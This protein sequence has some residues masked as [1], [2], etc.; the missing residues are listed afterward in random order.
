MCSYTSR[1]LSGPGCVRST[2][3]KPSSTRLKAIAAK[4]PRPI[5]G[6]SSGILGIIGCGRFRSRA[7]GDDYLGRNRLQAL[8]RFPQATPRGN[9]CSRIDRRMSSPLQRPSPTCTHAPSVRMSAYSDL[10]PPVWQGSARGPF[11]P[12]WLPRPCSQKTRASVLL[13]PTYRH[14]KFPT[15]RAFVESLASLRQTNS[16]Q[17]QILHSWVIKWRSAL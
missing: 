11:S 3:D 9:W 8:S 13:A 6:S 17:G 4:S 1:L 7:V 5:L 10:K 15:A 2:R 14:N 16:P 12:L